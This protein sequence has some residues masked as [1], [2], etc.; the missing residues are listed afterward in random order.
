VNWDHTVLPNCSDHYGW[1]KISGG[2]LMK[3][4]ITNT[5][6]TVAIAT[7]VLASGAQAHSNHKHCT[8]I[9]ENNMYIP[10]G[11]ELSGGITEAEFNKVI[12]RVSAFYTPIIAAKGGTF[13]VN[14]LWSNGT[15][16]ASAQ[17][18]GKTWIV[19]MY[20]GLARHSVTTTEGFTLVLCHEIGHQLGGYPKTGSVFGSNWAANE[21][22]ADYFATMK[23]GR[24]VFA[25]DDNAAI[26]ASLQVPNI[27]REK[28]SLQFKSTLEINVCIRQSMAGMNLATLL[29][30]LASGQNSVVA[31][32]KAAPQFDTPDTS[33]VSTTDN[34]HPAAQC[35]LDTYF[36]G[37]ICG[38][39]MD[40]EFGQTDPST[41]ACAQEKGDQVGYRPR[42]WYH[43]AHSF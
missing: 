24:R 41:G 29:H 16:N 6:T 12:D 42:C 20:G 9:P 32:A 22:Q 1:E 28:C 38:V 30:A 8:F 10:E 21:G 7:L 33:T 43:P 18:S 31:S 36:N 35:R 40:Q 25:Q 39:S 14:R 17:R 3:S 2:E 27:V 4:I 34:A 5:F 11:Q 23:C 19:N 37:A 13:K 26:V 15:V